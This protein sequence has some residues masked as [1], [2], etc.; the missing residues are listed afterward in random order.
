MIGGAT[1]KVSNSIDQKLK[2]LLNRKEEDKKY[3]KNYLENIFPLYLI[4]GLLDQAKDKISKNT[5]K[6]LLQE[7]HEIQ[8]YV[9]QD[10]SESMK[11]IKK[12]INDEN[13]FYNIDHKEENDFLIDM[14]V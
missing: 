13:S 3:L 10:L 2:E 9:D 11:Q 12:L 14:M 1:K 5:P 8:K 4:K 6:R 7:L